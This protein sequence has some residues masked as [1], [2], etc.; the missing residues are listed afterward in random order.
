MLPV[1]TMRPSLNAAVESERPA[2]IIDPGLVPLV[3]QSVVKV[4]AL[5]R[6]PAG[7]RPV[8]QQ[9]AAAENLLDA[10]V[11]R[12]LAADGDAPVADP[13]VELPAHGGIATGRRRQKR[14]L[15]LRESKPTATRLRR[16]DAGMTATS[17]LLLL[18]IVICCNLPASVRDRQE[19]DVSTAH[20]SV[21]VMRA[22]MRG[23]HEGG[24]SG[25]AALASGSSPAPGAL[26]GGRRARPPAT[27]RSAPRTPARNS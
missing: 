8:L 18:S 19:G 4:Q 11:A 23:S 9:R 1:S 5:A 20:F 2:A 3:A 12:R 22:V 7:P 26:R 14:C 16:A 6:H 17:W 25:R 27:H 13:E 10:I 21:S 24:D 15:R